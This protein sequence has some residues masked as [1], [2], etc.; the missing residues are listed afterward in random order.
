MTYRSLRQAH[1]SIVVVVAERLNTTVSPVP[2]G[3][4]V[5]LRGSPPPAQ[6]PITL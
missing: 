5:K 4:G 6:G 3:N 1:M 2:F